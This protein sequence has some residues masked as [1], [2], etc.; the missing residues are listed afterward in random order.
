MAKVKTFVCLDTNIVIDCA[1]SR[2]DHANPS[3]LERILDSCRESGHMLLVPDVVLLELDG[4]MD[5]QLKATMN[6]I[7]VIKLKIKEIASNQI[8]RGEPLARLKNSVKEAS[9]SIKETA[10]QQVNCYRQAAGDPSVSIRLPLTT[11]AMLESVKMAIGAKRPSKSKGEYGVIQGDCLIIAALE[12]FAI[13]HPEARIVLCSGNTKD[14]SKSKN[15]PELH[16]DIQERI[17]RLAYYS[18]PV[19]LLKNEMELS[20]EAELQEMDDL[21]K[22]YDQ[23]VAANSIALLAKR[24]SDSLWEN[25]FEGVETLVASLKSQCGT[26]YRDEL[27]EAA[28][29]VSNAFSSASYLKG[30]ADSQSLLELYGSESF[31]EVLEVME[32]LGRNTWIKRIENGEVGD[33]GEVEDKE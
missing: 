3:L 18:N 13:S 26:M 14:F 17:P 28:K 10:S 25:G 19:E 27:L 8:L 12:E 7:D 15:E 31:K 33:G 11:E 9:N 29:A 32:K 2:N 16:P 24:A 30:L 5:K 20:T 1:F 23:V 4:A 22:A 21:G 6:E